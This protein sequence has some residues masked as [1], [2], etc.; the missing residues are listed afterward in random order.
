MTLSLDLFFDDV[1]MNNPK[2]LDSPFEFMLK[3]VLFPNKTIDLIVTRIKHRMV[4]S[5]DFKGD[6][7][8]PRTLTD[9]EKEEKRLDNIARSVRRARQSVHYAVRSIG[10]DHMLT[11]TTRESIT[12]REKFFAIYKEFIRLVRTKDLVKGCLLTR[13]EKRF[14]PYV[15]VPELQERGAYHMHCAVVGKQDLELLRACWYVALGGQVNAMRHQALGA[16]NVQYKQK[17]FGK[18]TEI[19]KTFSLVAYLTKYISKSFDAV[20]ELGINRYKRSMDVPKPIITN[21]PLWTSFSNTG[22]DF[23]DAIKEVYAIADLEG[24]DLTD[25]SVWNKGQDLYVLRGVLQ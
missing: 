8:Y 21:Q 2:S 1:K 20:Q 5:N 7:M 24:I 10:A 25:L 11:L 13:K 16:I 4:R 22:G 23:L 15:A 19:H 17:R 14:Y 18:Q 6:V 12:D 9:D 3:R